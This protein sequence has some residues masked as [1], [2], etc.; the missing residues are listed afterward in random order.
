[1][2]YPSIPKP[3]F[4]F[5]GWFVDTFPKKCCDMSM[6]NIKYSIYKSLSQYIEI[7][8]ESHRYKKYRCAIF[9]KLH[10]EIE[11]DQRSVN[12]DRCS[13]YTKSFLEST[14]KFISCGIWDKP[15]FTENERL[16]AWRIECMYNFNEPPIKT[17]TSIDSDVNKAFI[18]FV[19]YCAIQKDTTTNNIKNIIHKTLNADI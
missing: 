19:N 5:E 11:R 10:T 17:I 3:V 12:D 16:L 1:M 9:K 15:D 8:I 6:W 2:P 7:E 18:D 14:T 4:D 13:S